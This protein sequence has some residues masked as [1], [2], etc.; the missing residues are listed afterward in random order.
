MPLL[1]DAGIGII[2]ALLV[3]CLV[4][5]GAVGFFFMPDTSGKSLEQI[6]AERA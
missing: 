2:A 4:I 1:A 3:A 6:E 5:S